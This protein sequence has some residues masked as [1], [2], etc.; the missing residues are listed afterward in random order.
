MG[1]LRIGET[2]RKLRVQLAITQ[3]DLCDGICAV[4]TLSRIENGQR[5][6]SKA[7]FDSLMQRMGRTGDMYDA[8]IS[9]HDLA[10]HEVRYA[11]RKAILAHDMARAPGLLEEYNRL[12]ENDREKLYRRTSLYSGAIIGRL[13]GMPMEIVLA[14]LEDAIR[15]SLPKYGTKKVSEF[16]LDSDEIVI[17]NNIGIVYWELHRREEALGLFA[18]L[19]EYVS[20]RHVDP[21]EM[22][23]FYPLILTNYSKCLGQSERYLDCIRICDKGIA[24]CKHIDCTR[25]MSRFYYDRGLSLLYR[26]KPEEREEAR[27]NII[28][29]YLLA[30]SIEN[31]G[32]MKHIANSAKVN[33]DLDL[34]E[35]FPFYLSS[36]QPGQS[37][38]S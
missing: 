29:A 23:R 18:E 4:P 11:L 38:Q 33:F 35:T 34:A 10:I 19:E 15:I 27:N 7:V 13:G 14:T 36:P 16:Y 31:E 24:Y 37:K 2:V 26:A 28:Y 21:H 32:M 9:D 12:I 3:E 17:L 20:C 8:L 22:E 6:P 5:L 1:N 30:M 25:L